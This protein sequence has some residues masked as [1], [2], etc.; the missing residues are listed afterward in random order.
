MS[1][2]FRSRHDPAQ[3]LL[4]RHFCPSQPCQPVGCH[5]SRQRSAI[6]GQYFLAAGRIAVFQKT[7]QSEEVTV[8]VIIRLM[9]EAQTAIRRG[10]KQQNAG[11]L[12]CLRIEQIARKFAGFRIF[13]E[14]M[15]ETL[16]L[17]QND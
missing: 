2:A 12:P 14:E 1:E 4:K 15:F 17:V 10:R 5:H 16:K 7:Q 3:T 9:V 6:L 8:V 11:T 13:I